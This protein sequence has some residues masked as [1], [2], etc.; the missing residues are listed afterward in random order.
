MPLLG[1]VGEVLWS[2]QIK[3]SAILVSSIGIFSR[4]QGKAMGGTGDSLTGD[5]GEV[6]SVPYICLRFWAVI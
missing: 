1:S 3:K 6:L 4:S 2:I 5:A